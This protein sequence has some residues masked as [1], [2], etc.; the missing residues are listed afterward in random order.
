MENDDQVKLFTVYPM[1]ISLSLVLRGREPE[2][3]LVSSNIAAFIETC[4]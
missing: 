3:D 1:Y 4:L 2:R